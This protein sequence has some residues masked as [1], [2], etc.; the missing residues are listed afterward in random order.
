MVL[1][2]NFPWILPFRREGGRSE[3]L[4]PDLLH[5]RCRTMV[6]PRNFPQLCLH[7]CSA[8]RTLPAALSRRR[9]TE[10]GQAPFLRCIFL[11]ES[12]HVTSILYVDPSGNPIA[13]DLHH[14]LL[15]DSDDRVIAVEGHFTGRN[16]RWDVLVLINQAI[17]F[18]F[19]V[20]VIFKGAVGR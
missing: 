6:L 19:Q 8:E 9:E 20:G 3:C 2:R 10:S 11:S 17:R 12:Y 14:L 13:D 4:L 5:T 7:R 16:S 15:P 18:M 1:P